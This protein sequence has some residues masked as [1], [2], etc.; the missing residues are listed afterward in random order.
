MISIHFCSSTLKYTL[1]ICCQIEHQF[2]Q[3]VDK[4]EMSKRQ[5]TQTR[6]T[7]HIG[8]QKFSNKTY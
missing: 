8:V 6:Y 1:T 3:Q 7:P 4:Y 5:A 2:T